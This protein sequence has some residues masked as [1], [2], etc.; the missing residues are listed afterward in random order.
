[1]SNNSIRVTSVLCEMS[2]LLLLFGHVCNL[3]LAPCLGDANSHMMP[4]HCCVDVHMKGIV[5]QTLHS[6]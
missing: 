6:V 1:M 4:V 3:L 2:F 5:A